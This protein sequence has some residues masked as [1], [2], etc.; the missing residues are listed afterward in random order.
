MT[1]HRL[2]L[3]SDGVFA[4]V[5]TL[6]V[7]DLRIPVGHGLAGLNQ[8]VPALLV[9]AASFFVVGSF[10]FIH[11]NGLARVTE[12]R[13]STLLLNLLCLFWAT[14]IPFGAR[15]AAE[16]PLEPLGASILSA[17]TGCYLISLLWLRLTT[18]SAIDDNPGMRRWRIRRIGMISGFI[19]ADLG[20]AALAWLSPWPA[21]IVTLATAAFFF[22]LRSP[23]EIEQRIAAATA[24]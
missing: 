4:I 20:G 14:L 8:I 5:L 19:A 1:K 17:A 12:V 16:R 15:N 22:A 10:W 11:H 23:P 2:E 9:H 3:F 18:H 21:Y 7:L 24:V 6:L 13:S